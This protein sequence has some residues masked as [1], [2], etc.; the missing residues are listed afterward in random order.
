VD[1]ED[2]E[3]QTSSPGGTS[4]QHGWKGFSNFLH[5]RRNSNTHNGSRK[6]SRASDAGSSNSDLNDL[7]P[8]WLGLPLPSQV[9][10]PLPVLV[11]PDLGLT[12]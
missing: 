6:S 4:N 10:I 7:N 1:Q 9:K 5:I 12:A 11:F 3:T 2:G 8:H